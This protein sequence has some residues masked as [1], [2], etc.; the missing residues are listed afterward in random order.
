MK[1][2]LHEIFLM[3]Y[4][5]LEYFPIYSTYI[6]AHNYS[7]SPKA[8]SRGTAPPYLL[9]H[10]MLFMIACGLTWHRQR[11][12]SQNSSTILHMRARELSDTTLCQTH[13]KHFHL[14]DLLSTTFQRQT[15]Q[16]WRIPHMHADCIC[17]P[18]RSSLQTPYVHSR[19]L[20]MSLTVNHV[21]CFMGALKLARA[22]TRLATYNKGM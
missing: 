15:F 11:R 8:G 9:N 10:L 14:K 2:F 16:R 18:Q 20:H 7:V 3:K 1:F 5:Q 13:L 12:G 19:Q 22:N 4:F 21:S 17:H 6:L